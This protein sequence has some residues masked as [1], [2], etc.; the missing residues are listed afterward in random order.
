[1]L[2]NAAEAIRSSDRMAFCTALWLPDER[3]LYHAMIGALAH[4]VA[5]RTPVTKGMDV[6]YCHLKE[7]AC[8]SNFQSR[9]DGR[10]AL[11]YV[12][13]T[14]RQTRRVLARMTSSHIQV[15]WYVAVASLSLNARAFA[16][17]DTTFMCHRP[18]QTHPQ[19]SGF[20]PP[21]EGG[22]FQPIFL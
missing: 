8:T 15:R 14:T 20:P 9:S 7:A 5:G 13:G 3:R 11:L 1:M 6:I 4:T 16:Y 22:G 10:S 12:P 21:P 18:P 19:I 2:D 17:K